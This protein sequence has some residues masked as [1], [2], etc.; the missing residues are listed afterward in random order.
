MTI[1]FRPQS[2]FVDFWAG[3]YFQGAGQFI[4][5]H[6]IQVLAG[7]VPIPEAS[8]QEVVPFARRNTYIFHKEVLNLAA[9]CPHIFE[10]CKPKPQQKIKVR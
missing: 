4:L 8:A 7:Y 9:C 1:I 3:D 2:D 6:L 5:Q 10:A